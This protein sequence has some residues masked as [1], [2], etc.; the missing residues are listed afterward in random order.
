[1]VAAVALSTC[2]P[3]A[4]GDRYHDLIYGTRNRSESHNSSVERSLTW[5]RAHSLGAQAQLTDMLAY[6][7]GVNAV[8]RED[9]RFRKRQAEAA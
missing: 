6:A 3:I 5:G 1:M 2:D 9:H 8:V 4:Y 7:L